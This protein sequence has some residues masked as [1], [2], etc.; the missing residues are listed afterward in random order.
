MNFTQTSEEQR[1]LS[2]QAQIVEWVG[3]MI[4]AGWAF[5]FGGL[6]RFRANE[7]GT[8]VFI[9]ADEAEELFSR[10]RSSRKIVTPRAML[11]SILYKAIVEYWEAAGLHGSSFGIESF[12]H[13]KQRNIVM[14][15]YNWSFRG[16]RCHNLDIELPDTVLNQFSD[17]DDGDT[18]F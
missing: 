18:T 17:N 16:L 5:D 9:P 10:W 13:N 2:A 7:D 15:T 11:H 8:D 12:E 4:A 6:Y 14:V 3:R 1:E